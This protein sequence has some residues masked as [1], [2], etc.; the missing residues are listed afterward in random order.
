[1]RIEWWYDGDACPSSF[2][3][4]EFYTLEIVS[5]ISEIRKQLS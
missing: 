2:G 3:G 4:E 1:M 5:T